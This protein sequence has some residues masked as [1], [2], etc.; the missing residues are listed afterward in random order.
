MSDTLTKADLTELVT[1]V[2]AVGRSA[3]MP[4]FRTLRPEDVRAKTGPLDLVTIADEAAEAQLTAA[5]SAHHPTAVV[6]GEEATS[7]DAT[8]LDR[9][10]DAELCFIL[11][12]IDGTSNFAA[13]RYRNAEGCRVRAGRGD[14]RCAL[15]ALHAGADEVAGLFPAAPARRRVG[16]PLRSPSVSACRVRSLS[17]LRLSPPVAMGS[18]RW[19]A[20]LP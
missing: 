13:G 20:A 3:V 8:L 18:R 4:H 12:P 19:R 5:L 14:V 6:V 10:A 9:I 16:L 15:L 1:L 2:R 11:D 17:F 7:R